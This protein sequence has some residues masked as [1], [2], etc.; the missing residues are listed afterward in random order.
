MSLLAGEILRR[1][2]RRL[3]GK[4][5]ILC[6]GRSLD[7]ATLDREANRFA[8]AL[9]AR[10][11]AKG[12]VIAI[13]SRNL[14]EYGVAFYGAARAGAVLANINARANGAEVARLLALVKPRLSFVEAEL[15]PVFEDGARLSG[16]ES[17]MIRFG[18]ASE[19][20]TLTEFMEG[21]SD[22][23]PRLDLDEDDPFGLTFT[24]GTTGA[25]K[26]VLVSH[27]ARGMSALAC[28]VDFG[29]EERDVAGITTPMF[30]CAGLYIWFHP[31][32]MVGASAM[33]L[34]R[35]SCEDFM[36]EAPRHSVSAAMLVPTQLN[37]LVKHANFD[38]GRF[39]S[40]R[41]IV[42]AGMPMPPALID[43]VR[44]VMPWV[45][46]VDNYGSS[47]A[48]AMTARPHRALPGK[49]RSVGRPC[50]NIEL[51]IRAPDGVPVPQ[52]EVGEVTTRGRHLMT[53]YYEDATATAAV[54][55]TGDEWLWMGDLGYLDEDGFVILVDRSKDVIVQGGEN[56]FP[57]EIENAIYQHPAV[58]E[59]AV[60]GV[61]DERL[62]E[63][64]VAHIVLRAGMAPVTAEEMTEF[65][66]AR[67]ARHKRPRRVHFVEGLPKSP[68][69]KIQKHVIRE[70]YWQ[71]RD[72]R[73]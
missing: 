47:E 15:L 41:K 17:E 22:E 42:H 36:A 25:P 7:Y 43:H 11:I 51:V 16:I 10:G 40:L 23:E 26:G 50:F 13:M 54:Y 5:A 52:G 70:Q 29:L 56:I 28:L 31:A 1:T 8:Q 49:A 46:L 35:W 53:G 62:G 33:L 18:G 38:P 68:V 21:T 71:N 34:P 66:L 6:G 9:I 59:C 12:D 65:C 64:P 24:G 4:P 45:E 73:I 57:L 30:H 19:G 72:R 44:Q 60:V 69:G 55:K 61:P 37:Y 20:E 58:Q 2:A 32:I 67:I 48:G 14:P 39:R 27:R 3:P 63:V